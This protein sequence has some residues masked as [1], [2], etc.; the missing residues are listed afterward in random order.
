MYNPNTKTYDLNMK[1]AL[2]KYKYGTKRLIRL[3][4]YV[5][6]ANIYS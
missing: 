5:A 6:P 4:V 3:A 1:I 2:F